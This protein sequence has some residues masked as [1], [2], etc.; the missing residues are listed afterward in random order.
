MPTLTIKNHT[1]SCRDSVHCLTFFPQQ[2]I[3]SLFLSLLPFSCW[4]WHSLHYHSSSFSFRWIFII[5]FLHPS[6]M[7]TVNVFSFSP[8]YYVL[9]NLQLCIF[10]VNVK[11]Q[12]NSLLYIHIRQYFT[13]SAYPKPPNNIQFTL[14]N[15]EFPVFS[16]CNENINAGST[17][18][19]ALLSPWIN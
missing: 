8:F 10:L 15:I 6:V 19:H 13:I 14:H 4:A 2:T 7:V 17:C 5:Y 18:E 16:Q 1:S 12:I 3:T 9:S 11:K